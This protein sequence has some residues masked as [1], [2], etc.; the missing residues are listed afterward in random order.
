MTRTSVKLKFRPS[1]TPDRMGTLYFQVIHERTVRQFA[2]DYRI[3]ASEW[4]RRRSTVTISGDSGRRQTLAMLRE[5]TFHD[6]E[7][8]RRVVLSFERRGLDFCADDIIAEYR[9]IMQEHTLFHFME[10]TI[11]QLRQLGKRRTSETYQAALNS[12]RQYRGGEG[13]MIDTMT[14]DEIRNYEASMNRRGISLNT[15][16]FYMRIL[17]ATYNRAVENGVTEQHYPFKHVYTGVCKTVKRAITIGDIRRIRRLSLPPGT[18][19]ALARDIFMFSFF[20]RG[21][22]FVDIAFL[23]KRDVEGGMITYKR[24]KTGQLLRVRIEKCTQEIIDRNHNPDTDYL[25]PLI[26]K[27]GDEYQQYRNALR[28]VNRRL[29]QV[30]CMAGIPIRLTTYVGRHSWG[31]AAKSSNIPIS[32]ISESMGHDNIKTTQIYLISLDTS[33]IDDANAKILKEL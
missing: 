31:S 7:R 22:A 32:V 14:S 13:I 16:S 24:H 17:R 15:S 18:S 28:L 29:K 21:M 2:T 5:R 4:D 9:R 8:L 27:S 26:R 20:T 12:F 23:R 1:A 6:M 25:F 10:H 30:G 11:A 33:V 19:L 3:Y